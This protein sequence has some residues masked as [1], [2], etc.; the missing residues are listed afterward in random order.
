MALDASQPVGQAL[1]PE[2][3]VIGWVIQ[4]VWIIVFV[5]LMFY[6]QRIQ[7]R[8]MLKE[9]EGSLIRLKMMRDK[10]REIAISTVKEIGKLNEDPTPRID[11]FLEHIDIGPVSL[12]PAGIIQRLEHLIDVRDLRFK[13]EVRLMAPGADEAQMNNLTNVL[14]AA[15]A[16]NQIYKSM[17][18]FY[19]MGK[20]T[21]SIYI[22]M[23]IQMILPLIMKESE[24]F[25]NALRAFTLGQPIGDGVGALVAAKL[26]VGHEKRRIAKDIVA[27]KVPIEGR[28]AYVLK[29]E[30]PG[31]N[32]GKPG[33]AVKNIIEENEGKIALVIV[34]DA[35]QKLEGEKP[36]EI[37]EGIGVAIGGPGVEK[38]KVEEVAVKYNVPVNA[39]LIKEDIK[40]VVSTMRKEIIDAADAA[41]ERI[42]RL[43]RER[44]KE[45]ETLIIA[46]IG[47]TIGI[48]Q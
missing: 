25:A 47:N 1:F 31:G 39:V 17:R 7:M 41:I 11:R 2:N 45:G 4:L 23:Q 26:M 22:I 13:D 37:A 33:E 40:D 38:Y 8:I 6:G 9:I 44:T 16:L 29:A 24:A 43:I 48:G 15:L 42:K 36:G 35:A 46:G 34:V 3:N 5:V 28:T 32:I 20:K 21:L 14:E 30:G 12:D 10:G 19:L 27:S 18:H